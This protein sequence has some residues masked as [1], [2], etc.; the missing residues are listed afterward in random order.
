[1]VTP[2]DL[3]DRKVAAYNR[4]DIDGFVACYAPDAEVLQADGSMLASGRDAFV[5]STAD[6]SRTVR[7]CTRR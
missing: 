4:H 1:M 7:A 6:S 5:R 3:I 2:N